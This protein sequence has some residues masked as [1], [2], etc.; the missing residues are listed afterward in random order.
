M[1]GSKKNKDEKGKKKGLFRKMFGGKSK[2]EVANT[3]DEADAKT[4]KSFLSFAGVRK[5]SKDAAKKPKKS[6]K[7]SKK[8]APKEKKATKKIRISTS[9][10]KKAKV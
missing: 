1:A 2:D 8:K 9:E 4:R 10:R 6:K 3:S 7:K 5:Q